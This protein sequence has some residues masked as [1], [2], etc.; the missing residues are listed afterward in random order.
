MKKIA[1]L[2]GSAAL[3][4]AT[5]VPAIAA[6]NECVNGTTGP[7]SNNTC[8][9]TNTDYIA[10]NNVNDAQIINKIK[11]ESDTGDNSASWNTLG[12]SINTG[13]ATTNV[14]VS[15]VANINTTN[16]TAA[17]SGS[18]HNTGGNI[19]T[20]PF[21]D[22]NAFITNTFD[23]RVYNSNTASIKNDVEVESET[24]E[25]NA[26]YNTGPAVIDTGDAWSTLLLANHANDNL[27]LIMGGAGG[28]GHNHADN[29][30]TGPFSNNTVSLTNTMSV[31]VANVNDLQ[32]KNKA[33]VDAETG[34]NTANKNTLGSSI[35][36]GDAFAGVGVDTQG[37]IN[38]TLIALGGFEENEGS[39]NVTGPGGSGDPNEVFITNTRDVLIENWNNKCESHNADRLD[40]PLWWKW[41]HRFD[42]V[43]TEDEH[44]EECDPENLGVLNDVEAETETGENNADFNTGGGELETGFAEVLQQVLTHLND[45]YNE[46]L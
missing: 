45:V 3:L 30:T 40:K 19:I 23:A 11:A 42:S 20:G 22:N 28:F 37:N 15:N 6:S 24:G 16:I 33:D 29:S 2:V 44:K 18:A 46:I 8:S 39:N 14:T 21:S 43:S 9:I 34:D 12:G 17:L 13:D 32:V 4:A 1:T 41:F 7:F 35:Y 38:T 25:N 26:D 27:T 5:L 10:V 31:G 36:S